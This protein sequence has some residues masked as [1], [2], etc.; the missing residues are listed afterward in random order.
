MILWRV[1]GKTSLSHF[2]SSES[3]VNMSVT[4]QDALAVA[5]VP[6]TLLAEGL[7]CF[8]FLFVW[9]CNRW[10][11]A[12]LTQPPCGS[13]A[14]KPGWTPVLCQT[15]LLATAHG[16]GAEHWDHLQQQGQECCSLHLLRDSVHNRQFPKVMNTIIFRAKLANS[17]WSKGER[18]QNTKTPKLTLDEATVAAG[19]SNMSKILKP[20]HLSAGS[21]SFPCL[22]LLLP[23]LPASHTPRG[24]PHC[25]CQGLLTQSNKNG[26]NRT[27]HCQL[28]L[29]VHTPNRNQ[30]QNSSACISSPNWQFRLSR[31]C[32]KGRG[33]FFGGI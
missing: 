31:E 22:E 10:I 23:P 18:P 32:R 28:N 8:V 7:S 9:I 19:G 33:I 2:P 5:L 1:L 21:A 4:L 11:S 13:P 17:T 12:E 27:R 20:H 14:P 30:R 29:S 26:C 6:H 16:P 3:S 25:Q 15:S 24:Y